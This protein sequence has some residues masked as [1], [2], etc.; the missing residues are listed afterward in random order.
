MPASKIYE[1]YVLDWLKSECSLRSNQYSGFRGLRT[2]HEMAQFWQVVLEDLEVYRAGS[3]ITLVDYSKAFNRMSYQHCL[4]ALARRGASTPVLRLVATSLTNH[5][6]RVKIG[7]TWS[8]PRNIS[9]GCPQG[10]ILGFFLFN[11][12]IDDLEEG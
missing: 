12:K 5:T 11:S 1:S 2:D 3:L 6:M 8:N 10:S 4:A 9:G 7:N